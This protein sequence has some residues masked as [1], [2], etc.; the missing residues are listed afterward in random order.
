MPS[1]NRRFYCS[2]RIAPNSD[3]VLDGPEHQHLAKV[4]RARAGDQ[5]TLFD[6]SG[7]EFEATVVSVGRSSTEF[8]VGPE[9][10]ID[11]EL[12]FR[13]SLAVALPKGDRQQWLVEKAVELGVHELIPLDT[14]FGVAQ[15]GH[16]AMQR[17]FRWIIAA[18]KQ[19]GRNRL[20][21]IASPTTPQELFAKHPRDST[22]IAHPSRS[23]RVSDALTHL[24]ASESHRLVAIG[25]E[26]GFSDSEIELAVAHSC[27]IVSLGPRI[28]RIETA[29]VALVSALIYACRP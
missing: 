22:W 23:V 16:K 10:A 17:C 19:C 8:L 4:L 2:E 18:S 28:L 15:P 14:E 12:P 25:P 20:M 26:G 9:R 7:S 27:L 1:L 3:Y 24:P 6:G 11:R 5:A 21:Q 29:A 13:L